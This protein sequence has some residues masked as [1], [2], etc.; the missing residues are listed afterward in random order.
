GYGGVGRGGYG[1]YG[2][3]GYGGGYGGMGGGGYIQV[4]LAAGPPPI[5]GGITTPAT[6]GGAAPAG[7]PS[8]LTGQYLGAAGAAQ[9]TNSATGIGGSA[10]RIVPD[11]VNNVI[12]VQSTQQEWEIIHKTLEQLDQ[13]PR[14]VLIDAKI[15][16]VTLSD[17]LKAGV[18]AFLQQRDTAGASGLPNK[19]LL[20]SLGAGVSNLSIGQ[21]I[22]RTRE[23]TEFL[24]LQSTYGR[25]KVVSAPSVIATDNLPATINVGTEVP[26]LT[27]QG[28]AGG[29][30]AGG[31]SLFTNTVASRNT[32]V[33][34]NITARVN[35]TGIVTMVINQE[36]SAA[37]PASGAIAS[38]DIQ[39]RTVAT[40]VTVDDG[41]TIS[42]GGIMQENNIYQADRVPLLGRIPGL[43][44][45]FGSTS[46]S[47]SKTELII[48][49][50][51]HVIYD[52]NQLKDTS[53]ELRSRLK[54]LQKLMRND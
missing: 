22:G 54:G 37:L 5:P 16:E 24:Q 32:G 26:V 48:L 28:L 17:A 44:A 1:G 4:P 41:D 7:G 36:V 18:S 45:L 25:T 20:A 38:P 6:T 9:T 39:K 34:L 8:N 14:Q 29:A 2:G 23:L 31:T 11:F 10:V 13:P 42:I 35:A 46:I 50:T 51:P 12:I 53:E 15:Y 27:S 43:G 40:Q 52:E 3:G 49:L 33:I 21:L 30:Q 47:K 19:Q